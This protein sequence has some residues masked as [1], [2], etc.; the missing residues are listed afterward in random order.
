MQA[1]AGGRRSEG[2]FPLGRL[3]GTILLM[4]NRKRALTAYKTMKHRI[5]RVDSHGQQLSKQTGK[6]FTALL[7]A[8]RRGRN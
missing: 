2:R 1:T 8:R 7:V 6:R 3:L 4:K 5:G